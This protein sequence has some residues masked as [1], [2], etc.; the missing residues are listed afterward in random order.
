MEE[1]AG[2]T[3]RAHGAEVALVLIVVDSIAAAPRAEHVLQQRNPR[4][5]VGDHNLL[6]LGSSN[7]KL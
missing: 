1:P 2:A 5:V 3:A 4:S 6:Q 7:Y